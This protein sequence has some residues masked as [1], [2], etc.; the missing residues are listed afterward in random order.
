MLNSTGIAIDLRDISF[1]S[2]ND[3]SR[4]KTSAHTVQDSLDR[5]AWLKLYETIK[6]DKLSKFKSTEALI[7]SK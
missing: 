3:F 5:G 2:R 6:P 1:I 7:V 4:Q